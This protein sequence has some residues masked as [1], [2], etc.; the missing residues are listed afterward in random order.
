MNRPC[1]QK[2][3]SCALLLSIV[4]LAGC[5]PDR[6]EALAPAELSSVR[7]IAL[8]S[9]LTARDVKVWSEEGPKPAE[10]PQLAAAAAD[11]YAVALQNSLAADTRLTFVPPR[12][13]ATNPDFA[14]LVEQTAT[15]IAIQGPVTA[16]P[17]LPYI[18]P[19]DEATLMRLPKALG[20]DA[21]LQ[22]QA[23][24][25]FNVE[26]HLQDANHW[27]GTV[28]TDARLYS[29]NGVMWEAHF[30]TPSEAAAQG[31]SAGGLS[32]ILGSE[33]LAG[34][35]G[36]DLLDDASEQAAGHLRENLARALMGEAPVAWGPYGLAPYRQFITLLMLVTGLFIGLLAL[37]RGEYSWPLG[38]SMALLA[39]WAWLQFRAGW[40]ITSQGWR[41]GVLNPS[42]G[43]AARIFILAGLVGLPSFLLIIIQDENE[44]AHP[45]IRSGVVIFVWLLLLAGVLASLYLLIF[46]GWWRWA[47]RYLLTEAGD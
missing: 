6:F 27:R 19:Q 36:L 29:A 28:T 39:G 41:S 31:R 21:V 17:D 15:I 37:A 45:R 20:V 47:L 1:Q 4:L 26:D 24:Y 30:K 14:A 44:T 25:L 33:S 32:G 13:I 10:L 7:R 12:D 42:G 18:S 46:E 2:R 38:L 5:S 16:R 11:H 23:D 40:G 34:Q 9:F 8:V 43:L 3:L 22:V 35:A